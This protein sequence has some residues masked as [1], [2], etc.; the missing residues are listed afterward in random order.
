MPECSGR[1]GGEES[2]RITQRRGGHRGARRRWRHAGGQKILE[3]Q[4]FKRLMRSKSKIRAVVALTLAV[5]AACLIAAVFLRAQEQPTAAATNA[6]TVKIEVHADRSEGAW[7]NIWNFWGYDEPNY[8]YAANGKKLLREFAQLSAE[9][10]YVRVHNLFTTGDGSPALKWG[11]TNIYTEDAS[12][13]P[14]YDF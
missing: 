5:V 2:E 4:K 13:K 6:S 11:S 1:C 12:G 10:V 9:P 7:R 3:V 14:V 8:T